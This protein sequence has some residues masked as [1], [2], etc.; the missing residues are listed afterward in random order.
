ME[1]RILGSVQIYDDRA[2]VQIVPTGAKQRALLGA[3]VAKAGQV[4]PA[5]RLVD[6]LWGEHPPANAANALQAHVA[7]LRRLLPVPAPGSGEP[8]H[9]WLVTR[10]M[11]Y[12]LRLGRTDTDAQRFH[13]LVT[14]GR[15]LAAA[16]PGR[17]AGVLRE[18]LALWRGPALEGSGRGTI[19]SAEASLLEESRLV[20]LEA[21]YDACLRA[22]RYDEITGELEELTTTHPLR[23]RFYELLMTALYRC[24]RQ[25]EALGA[26]ERARRRLVHDLGIEPGPVLR[27]RM[28]AIL[29]HQDPV[30][31][32]AGQARAEAG[33]MGSAAHGWAEGP[34]MRVAQ[35]PHDPPASAGPLGEAV[36]GSGADGGRD[37]EWADGEVSVHL[38]RDEITRLRRHIERLSREQRD[39]VSRVDRLTSSRLAPNGLAP[40]GLAS[41]RASGQ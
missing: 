39:L 9:E 10:P 34:R 33:R 20:A 7:R 23:E 41:R 11:G 28:E 37:D 4:M 21:L 15:A 1:F 26:Y 19:C 6:E 30:P 13:R 2:D 12:V 8:H 22:G 18:A 35:W 25:A 24:G 27:G 16:D 29:H 38:L 31:G 40:N 36:G 5:E 3:L 32:T 17:A 14:E